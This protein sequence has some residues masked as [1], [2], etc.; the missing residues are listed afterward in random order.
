MARA[1]NNKHNDQGQLPVEGQHGDKYPKHIH[2]RPQHV[3][4]VPGRHSG[5][6]V[7]IVHDT[8]QDIAYRSD[9]I[10]RK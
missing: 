4:K 2:Q 7:R 1:G 10:I 6:P 8:G 3:G 5:N 9:I